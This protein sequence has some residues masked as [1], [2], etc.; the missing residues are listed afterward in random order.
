GSDED[1]VAA[2]DP[3]AEDDSVAPDDPVAAVA[4]DL[5]T[6]AE[7]VADRVDVPCDV[8]VASGGPEAILQSAHETD[9]DLVVAPA[10]YA[11]DGLA[12]FLQ[13]LLSGDLD[14]LVHDSRA[15]R[16]DWNRVMVPVRRASDVAHSMIDFASRLAGD[17]VSVCR[18]VDSPGERPEA[19]RALERLVSAFE[20]AIETRVA[21]TDLDGFLDAYASQYDL[22]IV[23]ASRDRSLPSR[24][25]S[26]PTYRR[27]QDIETDLAIVDRNYL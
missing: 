3:V 11:D 25:L 14:V 20:S 17:G 21:V 6:T 24:I 8:A 26:P 2:D 23:G 12:N 10:V 19:E 7:R 18:C 5:E 4:A 13:R 1:S 27:L 22:V 9:C 15:G 16:T